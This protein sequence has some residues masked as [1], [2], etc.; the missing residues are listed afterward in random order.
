MADQV[1]SNLLRTIDADFTGCISANE[2]ISG[3]GGAVGVLG[4]IGLGVDGCSRLRANGSSLSCREDC[5]QR[6]FISI[7]LLERSCTSMT[8]SNRSIGRDER[9]MVEMMRVDLPAATL[10]TA[11]AGRRSFWENMLV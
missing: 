5:G 10:K 7:G 8:A 4:G 1:A 2:D 9:G 6:M 11:K 3:N